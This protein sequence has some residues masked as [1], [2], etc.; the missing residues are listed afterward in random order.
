ML[1][2]VG[3]EEECH[4]AQVSHV[5]FVSD[6]EEECHLAQVSHVNCINDKGR[7]HESARPPE[8]PT[9]QDRIR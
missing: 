8:C 3:L 5:N 4:S 1:S 7:L 6:K 2:W 9:I